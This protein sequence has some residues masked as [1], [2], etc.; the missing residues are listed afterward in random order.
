MFSFG[1]RDH[2]NI[3]KD[4]HF[5]SFTVCPEMQLIRRML[6]FECI[7]VSQ[8]VNGLLVTPGGGVLLYMGYIGMCGPKG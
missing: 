4:I 1:D 7:P 2:F 5:F 6:K 3:P 8:I